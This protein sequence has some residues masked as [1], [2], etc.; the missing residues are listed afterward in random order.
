M[1]QSSTAR[2][3]QPSAHAA[4]FSA[5]HRSVQLFAPEFTRLVMLFAPESL[6]SGPAALLASV[7]GHGRQ[8]SSLHDVIPGSRLSAPTKPRNILASLG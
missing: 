8:P 2:I 1:S 4:R 5:R 7:A 6:R 3:S